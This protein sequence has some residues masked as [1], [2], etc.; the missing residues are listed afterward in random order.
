[1]WDNVLTK[2]FSHKISRGQ[3]IL[4]DCP[5]CGNDNFN[6]EVSTEKE[7]FHCWICDKAGRIQSLFHELG[8]PF[9]DDGMQVTKPKERPKD[10]LTLKNFHK[11]RWENYSKFLKS[12]GLDKDDIDKYNIM[13]TDKRKF[14][15]KAIFPLYEG[16]K[17]VYMVARDIT[18]KGRYYNMNVSRSGVLPY[19]LGKNMTD[20]YLCEGVLDAISVNK[21]GRTSVIL[22]G[23]ILTAEQ[24]RKILLKDIKTVVLCLDGDVVE[25]AMK[26]YDKVQKSGLKAKM[27]PFGKNE[28][29]NS[30]YVEDRAEL[31]YILNHAK[32]VT[33]TDRV[34]LRIK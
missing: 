15:N 31:K 20:L 24:L 2:K 4:R 25:K 13:T 16:D 17:L 7:I 8:L 27:V 6:I 3:I 14:K 5:Y 11:I 19:Y 1:M 34:K 29:P 9:T 22:L 26:I 32:E 12:R 23:T 18:P 10:D 30:V 33:L 28:D 21:L